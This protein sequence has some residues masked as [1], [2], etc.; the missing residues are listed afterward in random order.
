M[1]G[2]HPGNFKKMNDHKTLI[3]YNCRCGSQY[4]VLFEPYVGSMAVNADSVDPG[5]TH[6]N[7]ALG[8]IPHH[9]V[10]RFARIDRGAALIRAKHKLD[11]E[12]K[13]RNSPK[14]R[15]PI[16]ERRIQQSIQRREYYRQLAE[17]GIV[18]DHV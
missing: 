15:K 7:K 6:F 3:K 14:A 8:H 1:P 12:I 16:R 17:Q 11:R 10:C 5:Q 13:R 9:K 4:T 2:G 18:V